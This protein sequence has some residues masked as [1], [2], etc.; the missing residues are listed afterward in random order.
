M[1]CQITLAILFPKGPAP[2]ATRKS[3]R[4]IQ[5]E[6]STE[7]LPA[8]CSSRLARA[9]SALSPRSFFPLLSAS[10]GLSSLFS[11]HPWLSALQAFPHLA[12]TAPRHHP[13]T[14]LVPSPSPEI[15]SLPPLLAHAPHP[16]PSKFGEGENFEPRKG[17][18]WGG[19]QSH[20]LAR[21]T[22]PLRALARPRLE[23]TPGR[24]RCQ[25]P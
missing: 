22:P 17:S 4:G 25:V 15:S 5:S 13:P 14:P 3:R 7:P 20:P 2:P 11:L 16:R 9:L 1:K 18:G 21:R 23:C 10:P 19:H 8:L 12:L 24:G 6:R